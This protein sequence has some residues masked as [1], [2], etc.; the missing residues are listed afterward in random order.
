M[1]GKENFSPLE[2]RKSKGDKF[3]V[4]N[5]DDF[6][7]LSEKMNQ[8][9]TP[10]IGIHPFTTKKEM[11]RARVG[12]VYLAQLTGAKIIPTALEVKGGSVSLEGLQELAKGFVKKVEA[13]YHIGKPVELPT[14]DVS[15]I[16]TVLEKRK[17]NEKVTSDEFKKF[18]QVHQQLKIQADEVAQIISEMLPENYR[19]IYQRN[20]NNL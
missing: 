7:N 4:F 15:I 14:I 3:G 16:R 2:Y 1:G 13:R 20:N 10:W 12:P 8:G 11:Q 19:G 5:P 6:E 18:Q 17:N 9:K